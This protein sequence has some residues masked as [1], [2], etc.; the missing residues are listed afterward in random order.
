MLKYE[1]VLY[2]VISGENFRYAAFPTCE[3][4]LSHAVLLSERR[5]CAFHVW[6]EPEN[7][8]CG[9]KSLIFSVKDGCVHPIF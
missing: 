7:P 6:K 9:S 2:A 3:E 5:G 8:A 1:Y 4:A